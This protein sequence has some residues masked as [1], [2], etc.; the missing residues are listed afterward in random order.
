[1]SQSSEFWHHNP[2]C[3]F[4]ASV[5]RRL[6]RYGFSPETFGY[7]LVPY[8]PHVSVYLC[9]VVQFCIL[10]NELL[11]VI[12][13]TFAPPPLPTGK[14]SF[15]AVFVSPTHSS[16]CRPFLTKSG[17]Q[18]GQRYVIISST[19]LLLANLKQKSCHVSFWGG[20][21]L[22]YFQQVSRELH[23]VKWH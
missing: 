15:K 22:T 19:L 23:I 14:T 10:I 11:F 1:V 13:K 17:A 2:L 6:F 21:P 20:A 16:I 7:I 5:H 4:S 12:T 3:C 8:K 9:S 18:T